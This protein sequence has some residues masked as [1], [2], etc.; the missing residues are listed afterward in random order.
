MADGKYADRP[1]YLSEGTYK[2]D[3]EK[4]RKYT[5]AG[6]RGPK[7]YAILEGAV[8]Q[9]NAGSK[10]PEGKAV[11]MFNTSTK[12]GKEDLG[13]LVSAVDPEHFGPGSEADLDKLVD[14]YTGVLRVKA[15]QILVG[16]N[17]DRP[18]TKY[19]FRSA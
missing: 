2:F 17:K 3:V 12:G 9:A 19:A 1:P 16:M 8:I 5:K 10:T 13:A 6:E 14:T 15:E 7:V 11:V 4:V 18:F